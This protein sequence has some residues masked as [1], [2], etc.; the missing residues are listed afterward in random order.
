MWVVPMA[1]FDRHHR[2]EAGRTLQGALLAIAGGGNFL[3]FR[4]CGF[5]LEIATW[6]EKK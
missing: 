3:P 5:F 2:T 4:A 1:C 6:E